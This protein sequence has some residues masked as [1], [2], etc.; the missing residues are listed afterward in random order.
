MYELSSYMLENFEPPC[1]IGVL[2]NIYPDHLNWHG[3]SFEQY[4]KAKKNILKQST[5]TIF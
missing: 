5:H 4:T 1:Y 2:I 3:N